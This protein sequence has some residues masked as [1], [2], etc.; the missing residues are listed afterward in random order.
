MTALAVYLGLVLLALWVYR[1]ALEVARL[2]SRVRLLEGA[3][4]GVLAV[5]WRASLN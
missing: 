4:A 1:L 2:A 3:L 5:R